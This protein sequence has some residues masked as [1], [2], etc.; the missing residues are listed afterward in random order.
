MNSRDMSRK[1]AIGLLVILLTYAL[2]C[3]ADGLGTLIEVARSQ[4][5]IKKQYS[6]E[7]RAFENVKKAIEAGAIKKGQT[8]DV[9]N[10]KYGAPVVSV[11]DMDGK[12]EDWIYKPETSS[13]FEGSRATVIFTDDG[14][15]DEARLEKL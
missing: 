5:D 14:L 11:K 4:A 15:V 10:S 9:I 8:K 13:F 2:D 7:T 6:H 3:R 1:I 12:R